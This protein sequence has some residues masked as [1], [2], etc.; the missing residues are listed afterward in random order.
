M[1][2]EKPLRIFLAEDDEDDREFFRLALKKVNSLAQLTVVANGR[3]AS[4]FFKETSVLPHYVFLDINMPLVNGIECLREIRQ[5]HPPEL[6]PVIM[7]ST[8]KAPHMIANSMESGAN[9]YLQKPNR[10]AELANQ[11]EYCF[12]NLTEPFPE[13]RIVTNS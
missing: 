12:E 5:V 6:L 1:L 8:T 2:K 3:E 11:L 10:L 4:S 7:L 9:F 13:P